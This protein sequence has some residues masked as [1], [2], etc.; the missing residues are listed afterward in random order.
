MSLDDLY[1]EIILDHY[2][3]PHNFGSLAGATATTHLK[4][5]SCG[6]EIDLELRVNNGRIEAAAFRGQGCSIS[7]ASAS[8]MTDAIRGKTIPE[9]REILAAFRRLM[10]GNDPQMDLG[11]L[12]ALAGVA[13]FPVRIKCAL[14]PWEALEKSLRPADGPAGK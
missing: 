6:D 10:H 14:L 1:R 3:Q 11:D 13:R 9:V 2:R 12:E 7:Q 5:P 8:M 4:N